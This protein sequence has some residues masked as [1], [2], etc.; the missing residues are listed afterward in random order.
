MREKQMMAQRTENMPRPSA[1]DHEWVAYY[2]QVFA[3][4]SDEMRTEASI[5]LMF[6]SLNETHD[7]FTRLQSVALGSIFR[8]M[9]VFP[10]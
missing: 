1:P 9:E 7:R 3:S 5:L 8:D 10:D 2:R 6:R 4:Y